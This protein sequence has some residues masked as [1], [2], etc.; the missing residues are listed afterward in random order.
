MSLQIPGHGGQKPPLGLRPLIGPRLDA[1]H[2]HGPGQ[3]RRKGGN[4]ARPQAQPVVSLQP[5]RGRRTLDRIEPV[6]PLFRLLAPLG[7]GADQ[8]ME[9]GKRRPR[10][11]IRVQRDDHV[12]PGQIILKIQPT[13]RRR[14]G[15]GRIVLRQLHFG[16][17]RLN[18]PPLP[19]QRGRGDRR[20]ENINSAS[21]PAAGHL[22][23]QRLRKL[24]PLAVLAAIGH[25]LRAV[26]IIKV[27]QRRL[28]ERVRCALVA[29]V[30]G[31]AVDLDG[32]K[33]VAFDQ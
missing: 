10:E 2:A 11:K 21:V 23:P 33:L 7:V 12:S 26:R 3:L 32:A 29:G 17:R 13:G 27:Q 19:R 30:L 28:R 15:D 6:H 14:P 1:R 24:R 5:G 20:G 25:V 4:L 31:V 16:P 18:G 9:A 8:L 22:L